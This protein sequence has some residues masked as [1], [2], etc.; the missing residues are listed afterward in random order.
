MKTLSRFG[1]AL[2]VAAL[3]MAPSSARDRLT[4]NIFVPSSLDE[5]LGRIEDA[6]P[7][8]IAAEAIEKKLREALKA[9]RLAGA[10]GEALLDAAMQAGVITA[11]EAQLV[12]AADAA[13]RAVIRVDDFPADYWQ[14]GGAHA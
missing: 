8:V 4:A 12:M 13:R 3:L 14:K 11:D 2:G 5:P 9:K 6:L 1:L 7:K 10:E